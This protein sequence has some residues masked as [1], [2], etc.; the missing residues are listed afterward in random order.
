MHVIVLGSAAGGGFPQW[1]CNCKN[2]AGVRKLHP[3]Y[4]ARTQS[5][6]A[7]SADG[8][9][10]LL[11]NASPDV[12]TQINA[13]PSLWPKS[14]RGSGVKEVLLVDAQIDHVTG[15]LSLREGCPLDVW[16]TPNVHADL[17]DG[18]PIFPM[19]SHWNGGLNWQPIKVVEDTVE[20]SFRVPCLPGIR[21]TAFTID[22]NAPPYSPRRNQPSNGDNIGLYIEDRTTGKSLCY[23]PGLG[24]PSALSM[25]YLNAADVVMVDGT[26][27]KDDEM[28]AMGVGSSTG[29]QMGHLAASGGN[30]M[31]AL[32]DELPASTLR[33][34]IHINNTNPVLNAESDAFKTLD[35]HNIQL[36]HDG[37]HLTLE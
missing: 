27:W 17:N 11:C 21:L 3:H 8:E 4:Q 28:Q 16:C 14:L 26:L 6:I 20:Y 22:S 15:L 2:C 37:L 30:G 9:H 32:L 36:A 7:I 10:W 5:S 13:T 25:A 29:H 33:F 18:F 31:L 19:L 24:M 35:Q 23:A 1:N 34:L 12:R